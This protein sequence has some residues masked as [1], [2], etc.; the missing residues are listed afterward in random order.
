[1]R[2]KQFIGLASVLAGIVW[3]A[4]FLFKDSHAP[5]FVPDALGVTSVTYSKDESPGFG[6]GAY[7][8]YGRIGMMIVSPRSN[9]VIYLYNG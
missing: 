2:G 5:S 7:Y 8:A 1:M 9:L 4:M 3:V 6:P